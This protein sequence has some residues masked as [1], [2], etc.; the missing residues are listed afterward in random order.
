MHEPLRALEV[1]QVHVVQPLVWEE[2]WEPL[3]LLLQAWEEALVL[4]PLPALEEAP[5][6]GLL[7]QQR[8]A[9]VAALGERQLADLL[10][11][12][13]LAEGLDERLLQASLK[14]EEV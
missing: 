11:L 3:L 2:S 7:L 4:L 10:Q 8:L 5:D 9:L 1:E 12:L 13:A 6:E 14:Q